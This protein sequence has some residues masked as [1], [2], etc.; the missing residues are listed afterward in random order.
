MTAGRPASGQQYVIT[1]DRLRAQV[2][3]VAAVLRGFWVGD[4][5][6]TETWPDDLVSPMGCGMVLVPWPNRVA[7]GRWEHDGRDQQLDLTDPTKGNATHGLL[8]NTAYTVTAHTESSVTL[9]ATVYPQHGWPFVLDTSVTYA[10]TDDGLQVTHRLHNPGDTALPFGV[11]AHPYLRVGDVPAADLV[12]TVDA[13]TRAVPDAR[14]IPRGF[15]PVEGSE[16]DLR[17]GVRAGDVRLDTAYSDLTVEDGRV[18]HRLSAPDGTALVL[19]ADE[20]FRWVQVYTPDNFPGPGLPDQRVA[21]AMEPMTCPADALNNHRDL[22]W[23]EP[24]GSW[25]GSWG[26]QPVGL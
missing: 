19:W 17:G 12:I 4:R 10:L 2:G 22:L 15:E 16:V 9:A 24:G 3:Q 5:A 14:M 13:R 8:R 6:C 1:R 25:S 7:G 26:L 11:G 21:V 20:V 18:R 23:L